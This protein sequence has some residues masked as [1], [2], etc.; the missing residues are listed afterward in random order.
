MHRM[1]D[2]LNKVLAGLPPPDGAAP[3]TFSQKREKA[4]ADEEALAEAAEYKKRA[5]TGAEL[6]GKTQQ[7]NKE[8][9]VKVAE[10]E[11]AKVEL[12]HKVASL[13]DHLRSKR[14]SVRG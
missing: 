13:N 1:Q 7:K 14:K 8:L 3:L 11:A 6:L 9:K 2:E 5:A 4:K 10:L 12:Q